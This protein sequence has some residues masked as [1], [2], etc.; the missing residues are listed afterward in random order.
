MPAILKPL[1]WNETDVGN[2]VALCPLGMFIISPKKESKLARL[3]ISGQSKDDAIWYRN[4]EAAQ[5]AALE[6]YKNRAT[7]CWIII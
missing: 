7:A 2:I 4:I 3:Y 5:T 1:E 6:E